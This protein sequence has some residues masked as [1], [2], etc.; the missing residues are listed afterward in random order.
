MKLINEHDKKI[1]K[2]E[3]Y[4]RALSYQIILMPTWKKF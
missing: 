3:E 4:R 2:Q 1:A